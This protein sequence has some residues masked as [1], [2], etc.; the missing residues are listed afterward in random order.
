MKV[1]AVLIVLLCF[2]CK[3][4]EAKTPVPL[5]K[6]PYSQDVYHSETI[7]HDEEICDTSFTAFI[8]KFEKDSVL[9]LRHVEFPLFYTYSDEDFPLDFMERYIDKD[10]YKLA[11]F[12][13]D[14]LTYKGKKYAS[15]L[16]IARDRD[17]VHYYQIGKN[18]YVD[19]R[20]HFVFKEGCWYLVQ[21]DD[22]TD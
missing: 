14:S 1:I 5:S 17:S 4:P 3:K 10:E 6:E 13:K 16:H 8:D 19:L 22:M 20:H 11:H 2:G 7:S 12:D 21:F 9:Q 18:S 15:E